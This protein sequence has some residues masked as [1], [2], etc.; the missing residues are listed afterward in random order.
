MRPAGGG[1]KHPQLR[2]AF[3]A[4]P[5]QRA[6]T[7]RQAAGGGL[8]LG[9]AAGIAALG[10]AMKAERLLATLPEAAEELG[11][12]MKSL[13]KV[14]EDHGFLV[15]IGRAVKIQRADYEGIIR[16]CR[17]EPKERAFTS[18]GTTG[19]GSSAKTDAQIV[20][21]ANETVAKLKSPSRTTSPQGIAQA[22]Q[23][24]RRG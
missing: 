3:Q 19:F 16:A 5:L 8:P 9:I 22:A 21:R 12:P 13:R 20:Q 18:A 15:R 11:V 23:L 6:N 24:P 14:A 2:K 1:A 7:T 17:S 4:E 10:N